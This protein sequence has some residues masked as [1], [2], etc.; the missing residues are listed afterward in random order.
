MKPNNFRA[1]VQLAQRGYRTRAYQLLSQVLREDPTYAPAWLWLSGVVDDPIRQRE[2]LERVLYLDPQ[3]A[4][5]RAGLAFLGNTESGAT[6][7]VIDRGPIPW[8]LGDYLVE[9]QF[10][11]PAQLNEAL[12]DQQTYRHMGVTPP[13]LGQILLD[14]QWVSPHGLATALM[15]QQ[16]EQLLGRY[17]RPP[18]RL[19]EYLVTS[20]HITVEQ[21]AGALARQL[22]LRQQ[23]TSVRLGTLLIREQYVKATIV[24]E[25][26]LIQE[27]QHQHQRAA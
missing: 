1:A 11:T 14:R 9:Y 21:L 23:G 4:H 22:E 19:G 20:G 5:A 3:C 2:C 13:M 27:K 18:M 16:Q 10:I 26:L 6:D 8:K 12:A 24:E 25:M 17:A 15:L 7:T